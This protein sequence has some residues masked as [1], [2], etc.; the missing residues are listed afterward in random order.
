MTTNTDYFKAFDGQSGV[1]NLDMSLTI[2][3]VTVDPLFVYNGKDADAADWNETTYG[4]T[5]TAK[6][7]V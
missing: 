1:D 2:N 5:L 3:F 6:V 7:T 4:E